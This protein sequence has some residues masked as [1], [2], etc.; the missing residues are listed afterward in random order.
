MTNLILKTVILLQICDCQ[1]RRIQEQREKMSNTTESLSKV[2]R[3]VLR[4]YK[5][6]LCALH[7]VLR[8]YVRQWFVKSS[9]CEPKF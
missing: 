9:V 8:N 4:I 6:P 7:P 3:L 1:I 5:T 2:H